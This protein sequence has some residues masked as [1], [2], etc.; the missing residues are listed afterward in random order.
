MQVTL[1]LFNE[2]CQYSQTCVKRS[3]VR[4]ILAFETGGCLLL[5]KKVA[6]KVQEL[7]AP[8]SFRIS[9]H[10]SVAI[11]MSPKWMVS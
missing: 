6:Q 5:H 9:H 10:L 1:C 11:S 8:L 2:I 7:F 4:H 3:Y